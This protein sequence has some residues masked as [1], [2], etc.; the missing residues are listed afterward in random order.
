MQLTI[1]FSFLV[2]LSDNTCISPSKILQRLCSLVLLSL[3]LPHP[4]YIDLG[5]LFHIGL[6]RY[7]SL[8]HQRLYLDSKV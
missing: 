6:E 5:G 7:A 1:G 4:N 8:F 3:P 2:R